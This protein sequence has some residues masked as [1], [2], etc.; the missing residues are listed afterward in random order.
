MI[1]AIATFTKNRDLIYI[2]TLKKLKE[3]HVGSIL[4][5][6]WSFYTAL[7]PLFTYM[8]VF[9]FIAKVKVEGV[10]GPWEYL[11]YVFSGLLPWLFINKVVIEAVDS[12]NGSLDILKQAIFP[13]EIIS[14]ISATENLANMVM[15]CV[16]LL[17]VIFL[18][19]GVVGWK[20]LLLPIFLVTH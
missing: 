8:L 19:P 13:M 11:L 17:A 6:F 20:I 1:G 16:L 2:L 15:Q 12:I 7:F 14:V 18:S 5:Y 4:G 10:N 9:F 3:K